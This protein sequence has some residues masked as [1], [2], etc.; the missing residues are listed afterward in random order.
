MHVG[1]QN[2][3]WRY[4]ITCVG[5]HFN[6]E[7]NDDEV[8]AWCKLHGEEFKGKMIPFGAKVFFKPSGVREIE[9]KH[10][11]DPMGSP[12]VFAGYEVGPGQRWSRKY[13]V[14]ALCDWR[15]PFQSSKSPH[16][17]ERI[18]LKEPL[19]FPCKGDYE[20][21]NATIEGLKVKDRLDGNPEHLPPPPHDD[22][23]DD[24]QDDDDQDGGDFPS[25]KAL[26]DPGEPDHEKSVDEMAQEME[27]FCMSRGPPGIDKPPDLSL[28]IPQGGPEHWSKGSPGDGVVYLNDNGEWIKISKR[29]Y[30]YLVDER[31]YRRVAGTT[32]PSKYTPREWQ[33]L[34]HEVRK[35]IAKAAEKEEEADKEKKKADDKI[36][37]SEAKSKAREEKKKAKSDKNQRRKRMM[38]PRPESRKTMVMYIV[39]R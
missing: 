2:T 5:H 19:E 38:I 15:S 26:R 20:K 10:K 25:S 39:V 28:K 31:G 9:Q 3:T 32:R 17:T 23:D 4:A 7:P 16:V 27:E 14:W 1:G 11:F 35:S 22:E 36:K 30:P 13:K 24:D 12:G 18:E 8:S 33:K 6:I 21:I 37:E 29:G 34:P